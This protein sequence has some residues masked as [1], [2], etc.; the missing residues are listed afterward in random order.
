[1][2]SNNPQAM[3]INQSLWA[4]S[5]DGY[6]NKAWPL[7]DDWK[8]V[9]SV[10]LYRITL[11]LDMPQFSAS[12]AGVLA[13]LLNRSVRFLAL[14]GLAWCTVWTVARSA[15]PYPS[16]VPRQVFSETLSEQQKQLAT[17]PL[18]MRFAA[19]RKK[20]AADRHRPAYHFV[21]PES[22]LNDPNGLCFWQGRWHLF[23]QSVS[24]G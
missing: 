10:D 2:K 16:P 9:K 3:S 20:L 8:D 22:Q 7:P 1:M 14:A 17:N 18:M 24:L 4:Y 19:S 6:V 13:W 12:V 5:R 15:E 11:M 23:Y 21:S